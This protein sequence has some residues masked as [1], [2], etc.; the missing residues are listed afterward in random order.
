MVHGLDL[1]W[2]EHTVRV[3]DPFFE[4]RAISGAPCSEAGERPSAPGRASMP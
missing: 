2:L 4:A 3:A 1:L